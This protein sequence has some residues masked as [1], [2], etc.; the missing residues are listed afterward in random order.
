MTNPVTIAKIIALLGG[1]ALGALLARWY[2]EFEANRAQKRSEYDR[3]RY[4]QG[5]GPIAEQQASTRTI[6]T[7]EDVKTSN[8][9]MAWELD[10]EKER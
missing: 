1:A 7:P 3:A 2:D 8:P 5:L 10:E 6:L 9:F 4:G